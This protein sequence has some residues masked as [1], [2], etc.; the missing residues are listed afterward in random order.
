MVCHYSAAGIYGHRGNDGSCA[1]KAMQPQ[2]RQDLA[3]QALPPGI[4]SGNRAG[5]DSE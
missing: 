4:E 2:Q 3:L 1:A 5:A